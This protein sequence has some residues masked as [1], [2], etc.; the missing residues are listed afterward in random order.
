MGYEIPRYV[1]C[2]KCGK[3]LTELELNS[4]IAYYLGICCDCYPIEEDIRNGE[5]K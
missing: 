2:V 5:G 3:F 1:K 4:D